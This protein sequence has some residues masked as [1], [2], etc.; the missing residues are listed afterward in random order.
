M[1]NILGSTY[2]SPIYQEQ[3]QQIFHEIAGFSLGEADII[4]RA[5][6]KKHLNEI[7]DAKGKFVEGLLAKGA[8]KDDIERFWQQLLEFAKYAFNKSTTRSTSNK[9]KGST[10]IKVKIISF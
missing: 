3:I 9:Q 1:E 2:G 4:R 6:S 7:E 5:M 10:F 8:N